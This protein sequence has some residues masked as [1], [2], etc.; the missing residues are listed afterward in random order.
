MLLLIIKYLS[1][2]TVPKRERR[3]LMTPFDGKIFGD[4]GKTFGHLPLM[5]G[6]FKRRMN[7]ID[8][9]ITEYTSQLEALSNLRENNKS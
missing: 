4:I 9:M 3:P 6:S 5:G 1:I 8:Q 7:E 2:F